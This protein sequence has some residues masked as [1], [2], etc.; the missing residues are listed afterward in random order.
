MRCFGLVPMFVRIVFQA[1][2]LQLVGMETMPRRT[3]PCTLITAHSNP[4]N[5]HFWAE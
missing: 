5:G 4:F 1:T 3:S 2:A